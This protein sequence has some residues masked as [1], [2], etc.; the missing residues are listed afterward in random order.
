MYS[1]DC[2]IHFL[3]KTFLDCG[4]SDNC[5]L[6]I[7]WC[8]LGLIVEGPVRAPFWVWVVALPT[9]RSSLSPLSP[10][11]AYFFLSCPTARTVLKSSALVLVVCTGL[12]RGINYFC[13][14]Q[15]VLSLFST[16]RSHIAIS[17]LLTTLH[18]LGILFLWLVFALPL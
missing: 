1:L 11:T 12:L 14:A 6:T 4:K 3:D 15:T 10:L 5:S 17:I 7:L 18:L 2:G 9:T 13:L 8:C 16:G